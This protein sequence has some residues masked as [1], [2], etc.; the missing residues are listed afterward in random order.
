[1][2][3]APEVVPEYQHDAQKD[4]RRVRAD[5]AGLKPAKHLAAAADHAADAVDRAGRSRRR[6]RR[7]HRPSSETMQNRLD[8]GGVVDLVDVVL[9]RQHAVD[10][11]KPARPARSGRLAVLEEEVAPR[12]R[13]RQAPRPTDTII[14]VVSGAP[15]SAASPR[16]RRT[17]PKLGSRKCSNRPPM[18][19]PPG[20]NGSDRED[21]ER[22]GH[23]RRRVVQMGPVRLVVRGRTASA[24]VVAWRAPQRRTLAMERHE[25]EAE[26]VDRGQQ[27]REHAHDPQQ[28][29]AAGKRA[30]QD[31][32]LAEEAGERRDA[33]DRDRRRST[34]VQ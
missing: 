32:V 23:R 26:H 18:P 12:S 31:F 6:P 28:R 1:M 17:R 30:E 13:S 7:F 2:H 11:R 34:N 9:V 16:A 8:D 20:D 19:G 15:S 14:S 5:R 24:C 27:R 4:G 3:H 33:G 25:H 21:D 22:H 10:A 29:V